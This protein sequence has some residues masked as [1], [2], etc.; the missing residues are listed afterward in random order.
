MVDERKI[1]IIGGALLSAQS[2]DLQSY[3]VKEDTAF[4]FGKRVDDNLNDQP[5]K[6]KNKL[7]FFGSLHLHVY[8]MQTNNLQSV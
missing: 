7:I 8:D 3:E 6:Y 5:V 2:I 1:L 4:N